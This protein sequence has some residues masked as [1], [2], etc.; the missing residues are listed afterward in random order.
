MISAVKSA[1]PLKDLNFSD[2]QVIECPYPLYKKLRDTAPACFVEDA[3]FWIISRYEDCLAAIRNPKVFSSKMGFRPGSV[4]DEVK[5]IFDEEGF[6]AL[7]DTLVSNDPPS[8]TR[9]RKLID[10]TFT[11]GRVRQ[12]EDYMVEVVRNLIR[13]FIDDGRL[14]V[15]HD[16]AIPVP[17]Y[18]IADQLGV[19]RSH[20]EKFKEWSDAAV[21]P[22]GLMISEQRKIECAKLAVEMHHYFVTVF[23]DRRVSPRDDIIS[24][25]VTREV[26]GAPLDTPELL[27]V[28]DQLLVAGN[29]TTTSA[30]GASVV[31]LAQEP[32]LV[33]LLAS[34]PGKCDNFA[35]EILRHESPVQGLFRMTTEDVEFGGTIIPQGSLV[36]LRYG[37]A[38]RDENRFECPEDFKVDR[39]NASSHLAFGAGIH[40]CIGAQL[41]RREI[42]IAVRELTARLKDIR[43][44]EPDKISHTP[45]VIL[46]GLNEFEIEFSKR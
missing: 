5:R 39:K 3:G 23:A 42:A 1:E 7:P 21:A 14:K 30:I 10:R 32:E 43:L 26:D 28:L 37:S 44:V 17:M 11:A 29:E 4:P 34:E 19:P 2:S 45:S 8:H 25:L 15:M 31:R 12:M 16:F 24:D 27:S 46:R 38:N 35:E 36:N 9:Y 18:V 41:A 20:R 33:E 22:L 6:G 40:H 13:D